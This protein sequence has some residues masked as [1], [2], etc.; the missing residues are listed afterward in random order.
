MIVYDQEKIDN[1]EE[2]IL[3]SASLSIAS[4]AEPATQNNQVSINENFKSTAG[5]EDKDL[6]YVQSIL[7]SSSWNKNDDIFTKE[8]VWAAKN[9]PEDKPTNLEHDESVIIGHI[10]S[11]W[12]IDEKGNK[13]EENTPIS[14]LPDK[15]HIVTGSVIYKAY[16]SPEL[17]ARSAN[18]ISEIENGT[19]Y[20]S[21]ECMFSGFDYG[22]INEENNEY[23]V[24]SRSND[25]AFLTKYL[26]AYGGS[27][28][29]EKYKVG[30]VLRNITFS[31]K[32]YVDRPANPDSI[33][34]SKHTINDNF[35][36]SKSTEKIISGV[37]ENSTKLMETI[38][39]NQEEQ[40][41]ATETTEKTENTAPVVAVDETVANLQKEL[42]T[43]RAELAEAAKK[44]EEMKKK[45]EMV[46]KVKSELDAA[47]EVIAAYKDKELMMAKKEK[48]MKRVASLVELGVDTETA[49]ATVEKFESLSD[50][51]FEAMT[52]LFAGKMP[53][54]LKKED[55]KKDKP[56][57]SEETADVAVLDT[58]ETVEQLDL[59]AGG[60]NESLNTTRAALV[61]FV[62]ARLGK[63]LNKGE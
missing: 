17:K 47:N 53:S 46:E 32:G 25:T 62:Y 58:A 15:F 60:E 20:V 42:E 41:V 7:V 9:T 63:K 8:E 11:N 48:K 51:S 30:R 1:L 36:L 45:E 27:G 52:T 57:A 3:A 23:K 39:M 50:E 38:I 5:Y 44:L 19:K 12:P 10:V 43:V 49:D 21:M 37:S 56:K 28:K 22:L 54:W 61:D 59:S 26:R 31:G 29:Y 16:S 40:V 33:I 34:F 18:L 6:Y 14:Q 4:I 55:P 24:L 13:I 35:L 2:K